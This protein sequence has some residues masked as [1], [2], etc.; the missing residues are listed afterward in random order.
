[1][2]YW[3]RIG[4]VREW[5]HVQRS[6]SMFSSQFSDEFPH[7]MVI[8]HCRFLFQRAQPNKPLI[9]MVHSMCM[10]R[11]KC[12]AFIVVRVFSMVSSARLS[13]KYHTVCDAIYRRR[14]ASWNVDDT[15]YFVRLC[16]SVAV[17]LFDSHF[18]IEMQLVPLWCFFFL[19][20]ISFQPP[21]NSIFPQFILC[22]RCMFSYENQFIAASELIYVSFIFANFETSPCVR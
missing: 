18:S 21:S 14:Y 8:N 2:I 4:C 17:V 6:A 1:M 3:I 11:F 5:F 19:S 7:K 20:T 22:L 9:I 16:S 10:Q 15:C 13:H 12:Q